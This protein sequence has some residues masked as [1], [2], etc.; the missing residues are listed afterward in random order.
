MHGIQV[1]ED[2]REQDIG[3]TTRL[4]EKGGLPN[5]DIETV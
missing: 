2:G 1:P 4:V 5:A 3:A